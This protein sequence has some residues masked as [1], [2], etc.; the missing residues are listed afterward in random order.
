[1]LA[2]CR[3]RRGWPARLSSPLRWRAL[4]AAAL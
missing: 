1:L 2:G 4:C 3:S